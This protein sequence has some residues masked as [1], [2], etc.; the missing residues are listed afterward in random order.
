V[1]LQLVVPLL[2][3]LQLVVGKQHKLDKLV[4]CVSFYQQHHM[5]M[6]DRLLV[7]VVL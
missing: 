5:D 4:H 3:V 1:E 7:L 6:V 2:V